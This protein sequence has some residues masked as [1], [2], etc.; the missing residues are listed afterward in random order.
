MLAGSHSMRR[1]YACACC[2]PVQCPPGASVH[3]R[4]GTRH[5]ARPWRHVR[6]R[7]TEPLAWCGWQ[8]MRVSWHD[9]TPPTSGAPVRS[10]Q[11]PVGARGVK[12]PAPSSQARPPLR[13]GAH[14]PERA[15]RHRFARN[16]GLLS[17]PEFFSSTPFY[18]S[19]WKQQISFVSTWGSFTYKPTAAI[20]LSC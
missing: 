6:A 12:A 7:G 19:F 13:W 4:R 14:A 16:N 10:V 18:F 5:T 8:S 17:P 15:E 2:R 20:M 1:A 9:A 11:S 3:P